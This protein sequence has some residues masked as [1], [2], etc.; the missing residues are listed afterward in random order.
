MTNL[1]VQGSPITIY[2]SMPLQQTTG[3]PS[4]FLCYNISVWSDRQTDRVIAEPFQNYNFKVWFW[5]WHLVKVRE[6]SPSWSE[7]TNVDCWNDETVSEWQFPVSKLH[8][9]LLFI[10][11]FPSYRCDHFVMISIL[12][13]PLITHWSLFFSYHT[14]ICC[15]FNV[16]LLLN[17]TVISVACSGI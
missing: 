3:N 15:C 17:Q 16:M 5:H 11:F 1:Y 12:L 4:V 13:P 7:E 2:L 10:R 14:K 8:A 9:L 6:R